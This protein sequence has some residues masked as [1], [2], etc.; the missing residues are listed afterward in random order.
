MPTL[1]VCRGIQV[2]N[3]AFGGTLH[4]HLPDLGI[5]E[6]GSPTGEGYTPHAVDIAD[7]S[8]IAEI[9]GAGRST[10]QSSHHQA[11][12][13]IGEGFRVTATAHD[14]IVEGLER[15]DAW[16]VG[17]QWHPEVSAP[18]EPAQQALF[19]ALVREATS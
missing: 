5:T 16:F 2:A 9:C 13:A 14:T 6:H 18:G 12:D 7:G 8:R 1:A 17:V 4:Q 3:V 10:V 15:D 11:V 19:D